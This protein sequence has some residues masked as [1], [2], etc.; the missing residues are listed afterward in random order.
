MVLSI[1]AFSK[2]IRIYLRLKRSFQGTYKLWGR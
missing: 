2:V 1:P